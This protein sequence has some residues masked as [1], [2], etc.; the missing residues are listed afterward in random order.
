MAI[1]HLCRCCGADLARVPVRAD[2]GPRL[3]VVVCPACGAAA[4]RR[5]HPLVRSGRKARRAALALGALLFQVLAAAGL[6]ALAAGLTVALSE[7]DSGFASAV[8]GVGEGGDA[9]MPWEEEP[10]LLIGW[11]VA[12]AGAGVW[13]GACLPHART[14]AAVVGW[15]VLLIAGVA[16]THCLLMGDQVGWA[17]GPLPQAMWDSRW[18]LAEAVASGLLGVPVTML[19]MPVGARVGRVWSGMR[20][21]AWRRLWTRERRER[22]LRP[23]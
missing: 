23:A 17:A 7:S 15:I 3:P 13:M 16:V 22:A 12:A 5:M 18:G 8:L 1:V 20:A 4:V 21:R 14:G 19:G 6:A 10:E 9:P 11:V 2:G